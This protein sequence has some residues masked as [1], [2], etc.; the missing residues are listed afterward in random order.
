MNWC[1]YEMDH[2]IDKQNARQEGREEGREEERAAG[3]KQ[4]IQ[5][6]CKKKAKGWDAKQTAEMFES[7]V[8][9]I[10]SIYQVIDAIGTTEDVDAIYEALSSQK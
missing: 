8:A 9:Q 7:D 10:S 6:I 2:N 1:A 5:L 4:F 3:M